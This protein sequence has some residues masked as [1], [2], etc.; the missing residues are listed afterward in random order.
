MSSCRLLGSRISAAAGQATAD[1]AIAAFGAT[2]A[3]GD[4]DSAPI[5]SIRPNISVIAVIGDVAALRRDIRCAATCSIV[6]VC[7]QIISG[8]GDT[9][10]TVPAAIHG[11]GTGG[12]LTADIDVEPVHIVGHDIG[13]FRITALSSGRAMIGG[14]A[15]LRTP[16]R[17][18]EFA[19]AR[20]DVIDLLGPRIM[21]IHRIHLVLGGFHVI[22]G[23][24]I[25]QRRRK[26]LSLM[27]D[28]IAFTAVVPII[29]HQGIGGV[30]M[31]CGRLAAI[32]LHIVGSGV[33]NIADHNADRTPFRRIAYDRVN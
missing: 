18:L 31:Q 5:G 6:I 29:G 9:T 20:R 1:T 28:A 4:D 16:Y 17:Q 23:V 15:S 33:L 13:A 27:N 10:A 22:G 8:I 24:V 12:A 14:I 30:Y 7:S 25:Q 26:S 3:T 2:A 19:C 11:L 21:E 32:D